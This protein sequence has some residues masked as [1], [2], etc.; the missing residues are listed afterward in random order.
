MS[1]PTVAEVQL[2]RLCRRFD[3]VAI[4]FY[5]LDLLGPWESTSLGNLS[6]CLGSNCSQGDRRLDPRSMRSN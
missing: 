6:L 5:E 2:R 4:C 3:S 1:Y